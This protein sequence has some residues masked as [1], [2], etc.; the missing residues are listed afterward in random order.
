M[1]QGRH[2]GSRELA[3][4]RNEIGHVALKLQ[5]DRLRRLLLSVALPLLGGP[6]QCF[7][8]LQ[9]LPLKAE[10]N[11][12]KPAVVVQAMLEIAMAAASTKM[13]VPS[14]VQTMMEA[15]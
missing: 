6:T 2:A 7:M 4:S 11:S 10:K 5:K 12:K 9:E 14:L 13:T 8:H 15:A 1:K 3:R